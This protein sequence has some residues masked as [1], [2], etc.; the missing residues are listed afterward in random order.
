LGGCLSRSLIEGEVVQLERRQE[1]PMGAF[2]GSMRIAEDFQGPIRVIVD[3]DAE[4]LSIRAGEVDIGS[5]PLAEVGVR[6]EDDGFHL[7][8]EGEEVVLDPDDLLGFAKAIGLHS[9]SPIMRRRLSG[10]MHE[11]PAEP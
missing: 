7:R 11:P 6:G 2:A 9:A 10:A 8:M 3:L 5:W 4:R 1:D